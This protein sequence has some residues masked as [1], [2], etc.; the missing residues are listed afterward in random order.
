MS[1]M[2]SSTPGFTGRVARNSVRLPWRNLSLLIAPAYP[3][4]LIVSLVMYPH[5]AHPTMHP[6]IRQLRQT[7][8]PEEHAGELEEYA[9]RVALT[10][11]TQTLP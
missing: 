6:H 5:R 7:W 10:R 2:S 8:Y 4:E 3:N 11:V 9:I 1:E